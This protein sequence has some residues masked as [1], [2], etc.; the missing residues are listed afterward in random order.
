VHLVPAFVF[1]FF[2]IVFFI[3]LFFIINFYIYL[4]ICRPMFWTYTCTVNAHTSGSVNF[5]CGAVFD[6]P[7]RPLTG[8]FTFSPIPSYSSVSSP[9]SSL[10]PIPLTPSALLLLSHAHKK[11]NKKLIGRNST[12]LESV[13]LVEPFIFFG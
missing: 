9:F 7:A 12:C 3:F 4:H 6:F 13:F 1:V 8:V 10:I 2:S 11:I 5:D